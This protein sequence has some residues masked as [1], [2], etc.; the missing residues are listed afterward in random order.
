MVT[1]RATGRPV[2]DVAAL[3]A[4]IAVLLQETIFATLS[5]LLDPRLDTTR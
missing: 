5:T 3:L 2:R 1:N 4:E